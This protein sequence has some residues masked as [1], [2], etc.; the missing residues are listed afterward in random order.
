MVQAYDVLALALEINLI[1][2]LTFEMVLHLSDFRWLITDI[3]NKYDVCF[4]ILCI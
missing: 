2:T 1:L 3:C 4:M